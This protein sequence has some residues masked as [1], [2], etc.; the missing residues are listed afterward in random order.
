MPSYTLK[1]N[2]QSRTV[3]VPA[4]TPLLRA[5]RECCDGAPNGRAL[6]FAKKTIRHWYHQLIFPPGQALA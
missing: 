2:G 4:D 3:N 5:R 1:I 6:P